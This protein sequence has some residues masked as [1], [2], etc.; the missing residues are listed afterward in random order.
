VW[1]KDANTVWKCA[2]VTKD[3]DG[4]VVHLETEDLEK[5]EITIKT[6]ND[7]PHLRNPDILTG[8]N[9][10]TNL[11]YLHEPAVLHNLSVRFLE[12]QS[13]YTYCGIVLVA[14]NPYEKLHIYGNDTISMYR[15]KNMGDLD[16]HIY[17]VAE[18]AFAKME[19]FDVLYL[20]PQ[21]VVAIAFVLQRQH[22]SVHH[23]ERRVRRGQDGERQVRDA[24]LRLR[25][26]HFAD[27][28]SG[29]EARAG[30]VA[31]HG[32]HRQRQDHQERQLLQVRQVHR[33]RLQQAV[34]HHRG[35]HE[36]V[37]AGEIARRLPGTLVFMVVLTR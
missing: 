21:T 24:L 20:L 34:S 13:I 37:L 2:T 32:G 31:H 35:Q 10:L 17:A 9:D 3:Y 18:E 33:D 1:V 6:E 7:L 27:R 5:L 26:R 29:G 22:E 23:C 16:P 28:D 11:S 30:V 15:G 12:N 19:R 25:G 4:K 14:I 8:E 36:D